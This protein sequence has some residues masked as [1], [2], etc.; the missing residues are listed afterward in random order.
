MYHPYS[1]RIP[2]A[3]AL[4]LFD[5]KNERVA[6]TATLSHDSTINYI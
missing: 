2:I 4:T 3:K 6:N 1:Y 5:T